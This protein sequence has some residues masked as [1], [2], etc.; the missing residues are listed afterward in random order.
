M[1]G[2]TAAVRVRAP[3]ST[4]SASKSQREAIEA[5]L[6]PVLVLAGPG[7]GKT[8]CLIERIRYLVDEAGFEPATICA[9]TFT[10]KAAE[11]IHNRLAREM[12]PTAREIKRS[13]IHAF[14]AEL[15]R[16]FGERIGLRRGFG[17]ADE[18]Y[19]R[20]VLARLGVPARWQ[21]RVLR[22]FTQHRVRAIPLDHRDTQRFDRYTKYLRRRNLVDFDDLVLR[23]NELLDTQSDVAAEVRARWQY[24]LVDEFQDLNPV[25][26]AVVRH[27]VREHRNLFAVGD[28]EQSIFSW[29]GADPKLF[30]CIG[31]DFGEFRQQELQENHRCPRQTFAVARRLIAHNTETFS[32]RRE[33]IAH[34]DT[35]FPV[36]ALRFESDA[37]ETAWLLAD[38]QRDR[39]AHNL[40]WSD[41]AVLYRRHEI[42]DALEAS[43][44]TAGIPCRLAQGRALADDPVV[45]YVVAAIKVIANPLDAIHQEHFLRAVLP[46]S[47]AARLEAIAE[48]YEETPW[49]VMVAEAK[50]LPRDDED[51][52]KL[53]K[54]LSALRNLQALG[55]RHTRLSALVEELLSQ[56]VGECKSVLELR[57]DELSDPAADPDVVSLADRLEMA[58]ETQR[59]VAVS[60]LGGMGIAV[61]GMLLAAGWSQTVLEEPPRA[62]RIDPAAV[63]RLG[64]A[65]GTF[66]ALQLVAARRA[67]VPFRDFTAIDLETT[68][69]NADTCEI[70]EIAAVR[71]RD[72]RLVDEFRTLVRPGIPIAPAATATHGITDA[73]VAT[74]PS[75]EEVWPAFRDFCGSDVLVA[76]NGYQF[77]FRILR[78]LTK[79]LGG[80]PLTTY[81]SLLL[82]RELHP[83]SRRLEDLARTFGIDAGQ[84]HR[85]LDDTRTLAQ[86]F[87]RLD[88]ERLARSRKTALVTL[89]DHLGAAL[90]LSDHES[91]GEEARLFLD[92]ARPWTLGRYGEAL[93]HYRVTRELLGDPALPR[94]DDLIER[95]GGRE[96]MMRIRAEKTPDQRYPVAMA[97][98][99]R[100]LDQCGTGTL[101]EQIASLLEQIALSRS[102]GETV[103]QGRVTLLTLHSTKGLEFSR[104]YIVGVEDTELPGW[105]P[106]RPPS[107]AEVE[108]GRRLLY[109][110][111]TRA[112][113][114]LVLTCA[115]SRQGR[116]TGGHQFLDEMQV[117]PERVGD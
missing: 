70:V 28:D 108:E 73:D 107:P 111:M 95:L 1:N 22:S 16:E 10:N 91:L 47:L 46:R 40:D 74:A 109:V 38:M 59:V 64:L 23:T 85:A 5:G 100:L 44:V 61:Q 71:V 98:L 42:G 76:H 82:A 45:A 115:A 13:T 68:D 11:E 81:D 43:F 26:Y 14:C 92:L 34:R 48:E 77:D 96:R 27:L 62:E 67:A 83:G 8:F 97:R 54:G 112:K 29:T 7:A 15:L 105:S 65:L 102:D 86:V 19:Q 101:Q 39:Q 63:P 55:H 56:R 53:R 110:G 93:D 31:T 6:G 25:Q 84:S 114:R 24:V 32:Q 4:L 66:K 94:L 88:A 37:Q 20:S 49:R 104:V 50:R 113:E 41:Y 3:S 30:H 78:R 33:I 51:G 18:E 87:L 36:R 72:G 106:G 117:V 58:A 57:H 52:R 12:G 80:S 35:T 89:L 21:G 9:F 116:P 90:A 99:R 2:T 79:P 17:I 103:E 75:F 60:P 69:K